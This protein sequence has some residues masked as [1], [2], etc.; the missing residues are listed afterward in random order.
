MGNFFRIREFIALIDVGWIWCVKIKE[1]KLYTFSV[2]AADAKNDRHSFTGSGMCFNVWSRKR[3]LYKL[4]SYDFD[5]YE[6][7]PMRR[8]KEKCGTTIL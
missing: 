8:D 7:C 2:Y 3:M 5:E 4:R 6:W 1:L